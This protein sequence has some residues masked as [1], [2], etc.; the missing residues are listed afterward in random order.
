MGP[1]PC[2]RR[3]QGGSGQPQRK[4]RCT[5]VGDQLLSRTSSR[6]GPARPSEQEARQDTPGNGGAPPGSRPQATNGT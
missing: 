1:E 5:S 3:P 4:A 6:P 2:N